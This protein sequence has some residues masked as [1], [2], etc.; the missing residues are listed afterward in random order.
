MSSTEEYPDVIS[1][2]FNQ[3]EDGADSMPMQ[4]TGFIS[5]FSE[6]FLGANRQTKKYCGP[7]SK[8]AMGKHLSLSTGVFNSQ[9]DLQHMHRRGRFQ[10]AVISGPWEHSSYT[11]ASTNLPDGY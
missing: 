6:D 9:G 10:N 5:S 1:Q 8:I 4:F 11:S 2:L 3:G 7:V